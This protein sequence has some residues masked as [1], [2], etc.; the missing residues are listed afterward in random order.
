MAGGTTTLYGTSTYAGGTTVNS[1]AAFLLGSAAATGSSSGSLVVNGGVVDLSGFSPTAG[2]VSLASGTI[3]DSVGFGLLTAS[4]YSLQSGTVSTAI[5]GSGA[6]LSKTTA[7]LVMLTAAN[8]Y[9]GPTT[10][11]AGTLQ[12]GATGTL[13]SGNLTINPGGVLDVTSYSSGGYTFGAGVLTAGRTASFATDINGNLNVTNAALAQTG[14][15]ST[16]TISGS[17]SLTSGT[18]NYYSGDTISLVGGG[19]LSQ[20]GGDYINLLTPVGT[21]TYTLITGGSVAAN[22]AS[23]L[24]LIG[25]TSSRQ[26][27]AF[28]VS[29]NTA[30]TLTVSG[31]PATSAGPAEITRRGI[32]ARRKAGSTPR[33]ARPTSSLRATT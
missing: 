3:T 13:G 20:G 21:G 10:I 28:N 9:T 7:G 32:P 14:S 25:D 31:R 11:N 18:I 29:G 2:T 23:Y 27:Y 19:V 17:L 24:S 22:P 5:G 8:S 12:L 1:G 30:V 26:N 6:V 16:M 33:P 15:S 4:T